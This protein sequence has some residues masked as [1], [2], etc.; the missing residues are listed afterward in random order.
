MSFQMW[1]ERLEK[2]PGDEQHVKELAWLWAC[3]KAN[4]GINSEGNG[5]SG[6]V[7]SSSSSSGSSSSD[8][9]GSGAFGDQDLRSLDTSAPSSAIATTSTSPSPSS[10]H[11]GFYWCYGRPESKATTSKRPQA[12]HELGPVLSKQI[13]SAV[14]L[15]VLQAMVMVGEHELELVGDS[16][17]KSVP[18]LVKVQDQLLAPLT[19]PVPQAPSSSFSFSSSSSSSLS[20]VPSSSSSSKQV[21]VD[22][23]SLDSCLLFT[24]ESLDDACTQLGLQIALVSACCNGLLSYCS[25][26]RWRFVVDAPVAVNSSKASSSMEMQRMEGVEREGEQEGEG[27]GEKKEQAEAKEKTQGEGEEEEGGKKGALPSLPSK[28][29]AIAPH[30]EVEVS[31]KKDVPITARDLHTMRNLFCK[32]YTE[33]VGII[34]SLTVYALFIPLHTPSYPFIPLHTPSYPYPLYPYNQ[35]SLPLPRPSSLASPGI[36]F[37]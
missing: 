14:P 8:S 2:N 28:E 29:E 1:I 32:E 15:A 11:C 4:K 7:T 33:K 18:V 27:L 24:F 37:Q 26:F 34:S 12:M 10:F 31:K 35:N 30:Q 5:S 13:H 22:C 19:S 9:N 25:G 20:L 23:L 21:K 17:S 3:E 36:S 6:N 16:V